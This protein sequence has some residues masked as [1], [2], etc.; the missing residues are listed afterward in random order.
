MAFDNMKTAIAKDVLLAYPDY[1]QESEVCTDSSKFQLG[2][3][4]AQNNRLLVFFTT[5]LKKAQQKYNVTKQELRQCITMYTD[6]KNL[7]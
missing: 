1:S 7:M 5:Y 3:V 6:N 2:A 4:I